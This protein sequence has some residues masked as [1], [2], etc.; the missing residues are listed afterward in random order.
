MLKLHL[1]FPC[2]GLALGLLL[3][4]QASA[5][6]HNLPPLIVAV[7][8]Q[9]SPLA[10]HKAWTPILQKLSE[11]TGLVFDL[12]IQQSIPDFEASLSNGTPDLA[13]MNPYHQL[14]AKKQQGYIPLIRDTKQMLTGILV[15]RKDSEVNAL[16]DLNGKNLAFPAPNAFAASLLIRALLAENQVKSDPFYLK[17]HSNVYR[18]V[19]MGDVAAGGGVNNTFQREPDDIKDQ[20]RVLYVTPEFAAHP[21]SAHPRVS[22][23]IR[24]KII[25]GLIRLS[26]MPEN[27]ELFNAIQIPKP[28]DANYARDYQPLE[29]L[30]LEKFAVSG[31]D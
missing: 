9:L 22:E 29:R 18:A 7:V 1:S 17:T 28:V 8:P 4:F 24:N 15:V 2:L 27:A 5:D 12:N 21:L 16:N 6:S 10:L 11:Q 20:L 30:G 31:S 19:L 25:S 13:F 26:Q 3:G 14:V 23:E